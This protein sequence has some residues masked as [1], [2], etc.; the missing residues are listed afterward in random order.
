MSLFIF[1]LVL[2]NLLFPVTPFLDLTLFQP[3]IMQAGTIIPTSSSFSI[4]GAQYELIERVRR[5]GSPTT[6]AIAAPPLSHTNFVTDISNSLTRSNEIDSF[7]SILYS[8]SCL[9]ANEAI[10]KS[11]GE[12]LGSDSSQY[13]TNE[14]IGRGHE[15]E[16]WRA[17][18]IDDN[19]SNN[20]N[21]ENYVIKRLFPGRGA[22]RS[23]WREIH[24]GLEFRNISGITRFIEYFTRTSSAST[25]NEN[26]E[27][28]LVFKDEGVSLQ[29]LL[30]SRIHNGLALVPTPFWI[31]LRKSNEG[32]GVYK[33]IAKSLIDSLSR[34]HIRN[35]TM[36]R[37]IKPGNVLVGT[38]KGSL[39]IKL[40]D[41][42]SAIDDYSQQFLYDIEGP[43]LNEQTSDFSPPETIISG[44]PFY[45]SRPQSYD[46]FSL[47]VLLLEILLGQT[48]SS[49]FAPPAKV[50]AILRQQFD[51]DNTNDDNGQLISAL[52]I[53][54]FLSLCIS[55]PLEDNTPAIALVRK[56][57]ARAGGRG[58]RG[59]KGEECGLAGFRKALRMLDAQATL[60]AN[61][62]SASAL[63]EQSLQSSLQKSTTK[64]S[65]SSSLISSSNVF[66]IWASGGNK[67]ALSN[68]RSNEATFA[69]F[70]DEALVPWTPLA[71]S[72]SSSSLSS[73]L[74]PT[75]T[76]LPF[77]YSKN[78]ISTLESSEMP[79][80]SSPTPSSGLSLPVSFLGEDGEDFLFQLL[81]WNPN[82]RLIPIEALQHIYFKN[83]K[84]LDEEN[85]EL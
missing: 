11:N 10:V 78:D 62:L 49:I 39:E 42:G 43:S 37:D 3:V 69:V 24:F 4:S 50:A 73:S 17:R 12:A 19:K 2:I 59:D 33:K 8:E 1:I 25:E 40:A 41:F 80:S 57:M 31:R 65:S 45:L 20:D 7:E 29:S 44:Q 38:E 46:A 81:M 52:R 47:G 16:V 48:S 18:R 63:A 5:I 9:I 55:P 21:D 36:H 82:K 79:T 58:D 71:T 26:D 27:L 67:N 54:G 76:P 84:T 34:I 72:S 6:G 77:I 35:H 74:P 64:S 14:K 32:K 22:I 60:R 15:G 30:F 75:P 28:W 53:A 66:N 68:L 13:A 23:G 83:Y 61:K 85:E 51:T 56:A 70:G